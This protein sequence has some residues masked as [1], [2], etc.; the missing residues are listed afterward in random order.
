MFRAS[1]QS[2][3]RYCHTG[4]S[5]YE[6]GS[7]RKTI[8]HSP[9][10]WSQGVIAGRFCSHAAVFIPRIH[11]C[12]HTCMV[13][14]MSF[15][16]SQACQTSCAL[17]QSPPQ[18]S[19]GA[20][21]GQRTEGNCIRLQQ[22][23]LVL[24]QAEFWHDLSERTL[25]SRR[26]QAVNVQEL[27]PAL[28]ARLKHFQRFTA[29]HTNETHNKEKQTPQILTDADKIESEVANLHTAIEAEKTAVEDVH[30]MHQQEVQQKDA[31]VLAQ[32]VR[33]APIRRQ[34]GR[35]PNCLG[36]CHLHTDFIHPC[37]V[38][39]LASA[40]KMNGCDVAGAS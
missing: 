34:P 16:T 3:T 6:R 20:E 18:G 11:V 7:L 8:G 32:D 37:S 31:R 24:C 26:V 40:Y 13:H 5:Q 39:C 9:Y 14:H 36:R 2:A 28:E 1:L 30:T 25:C 38:W 35:Q 29:Q 27:G 22:C 15:L 21:E 12:V 19:E 17:E 4:A 23:R 10:I 33:T